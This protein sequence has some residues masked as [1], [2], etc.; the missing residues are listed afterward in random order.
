[1]SAPKDLID[2][3]LLKSTEGLRFP[4]MS[5][6]EKEE[7][8]DRTIEKGLD[9]IGDDR[10][11][12]MEGIGGIYRLGVCIDKFV[13]WKEVLSSMTHDFLKGWNCMHGNVFLHFENYGTDKIFVSIYSENHPEKT[14][15]KKIV[16]DYDFD[17]TK[18]FN[19]FVALPTT[20]NKKTSVAEYFKAIA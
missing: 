18:M 20:E 10:D 1:M 2:D 3:L 14:F 16:F 7:F 15:R 12:A 11:L 19:E 8:L 5:S 4:F 6:Y 9:Y 13:L 17:S